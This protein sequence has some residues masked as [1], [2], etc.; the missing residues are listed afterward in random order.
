MW[1]PILWLALLVA[2]WRWLRQPAHVEWETGKL[3]D[4]ADAPGHAE[5]IVRPGLDDNG[6]GT[7]TMVIPRESERAGEPSK[8]PI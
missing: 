5:P 8:D 7:Y 1:E 3:P 6:L 2:A 4:I